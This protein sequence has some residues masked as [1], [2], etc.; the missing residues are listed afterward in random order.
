MGNVGRERPTAMT[1]QAASLPWVGAGGLVFTGDDVVE[2]F[3]E[4]VAR[5]AFGEVG[6]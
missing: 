2:E 5:F 4:V 3:D 6:S 1:K